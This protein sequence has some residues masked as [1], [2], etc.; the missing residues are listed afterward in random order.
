MVEYLG[1][2]KTILHDLDYSQNGL[3]HAF[4]GSPAVQFF[5][6]KMHSLRDASDKS[7]LKAVD[8]VPLSYMSPSFISKYLK[9]AETFSRSFGALT[10][11][12]SFSEVQKLTTTIFDL[13]TSCSGFLFSGWHE[14]FNTPEGIDILYVQLER[15][16]DRVKY[17]KDVIGDSSEDGGLRAQASENKF[18]LT[19]YKFLLLSRN[20]DA[21]I[22]FSD[23]PDDICHACRGGEDKTGKHCLEGNIDDGGSVNSDRDYRD[24]LVSML[25]DNTISL[26]LKNSFQI[27]AGS[28]GKD[29]RISVPM[30]VLFDNEVQKE[31]ESHKY[32]VVLARMDKL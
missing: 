7:W 3:N 15:L 18:F 13:P 26:E 22:L 30:R 16:K 9:D 4:E 29:I 32:Q 20:P 23:K 31:I 8:E 6:R 21:R 19:V 24:G 10:K 5:F 12:L 2:L 28:S 1:S 14:K 27:V 17:F 25:K 11:H